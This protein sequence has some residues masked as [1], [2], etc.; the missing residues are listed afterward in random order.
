MVHSVGQPATVRLPLLEVVLPLP[1]VAGSV[2][3]VLHQVV[4]VPQLEVAVHFGVEVVEPVSDLAYPLSD[5]Y[6][7][8]CRS[9]LAA[10]I[11]EN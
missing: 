3:A 4:A 7:L 9:R 2:E 5:Y 11:E 10:A 6:C 8:D 1:V